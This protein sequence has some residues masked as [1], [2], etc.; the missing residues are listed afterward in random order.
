MTVNQMIRSRKMANSQSHM[1]EITYKKTA[2]NAKTAACTYQQLLISTLIWL[3]Q[4]DL[5]ILP[6]NLAASRFDGLRGRQAAMGR[7][8]QDAQSAECSCGGNGG[9][10]GA[11]AANGVGR[12]GVVEFVD[13]AAAKCFDN[14]STLPLQTK[15]Q[16]V[17]F[18]TITQK[19]FYL[20]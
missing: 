20:D 16:M 19:M 6:A 8:S 9:I 13:E 17:I 18:S 1:R 15:K 4:R 11:M 14:M 2:Y 12:N 10:D 3:W 5:S 7:Q